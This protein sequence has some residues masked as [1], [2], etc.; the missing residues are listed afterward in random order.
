M[1]QPTSR[2]LEIAELNKEG[3]SVVYFEY[4]INYCSAIILP[5]ISSLWVYKRFKRVNRYGHLSITSE[6]SE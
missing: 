6:T 4:S 3:I 1:G 2:G 5:L